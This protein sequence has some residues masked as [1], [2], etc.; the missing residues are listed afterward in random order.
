MAEICGSRHLQYVIVSLVLLAAS[1]ILWLQDQSPGCRSARVCCHA[2][3]FKLTVYSY[4]ISYHPYF[5]ILPDQQTFLAEY[6]DNRLLLW[7][8]LAIASKGH[9]E[10]PYLY[11]SLVDPVRALAADIYAPQSRSLRTMQALLLLCVWPFPFQQTVN[12]PSSMYCS[13]A[14][15]IGYQL[16]LHRPLHR[17]DFYE[18][19]EQPLQC[20]AVEKKTWYGCFIANQG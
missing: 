15:N 4:F 13:L 17:S 8:V 11:S 12:D 20:T 16:G 19:A 2:K 3:D 9:D 5:P 6:D 14:T 18:G 7:T 10:Y 1:F